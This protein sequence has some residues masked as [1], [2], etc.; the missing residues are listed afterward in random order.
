MHSMA[1]TLRLRGRHKSSTD[2]S[3][4]MLYATVGIAYGAPIE[5]VSIAMKLNCNEWQRNDNI[6]VE[7]MRGT[8]WVGGSCEVLNHC[9]SGVKLTY[10]YLIIRLRSRRFPLNEKWHLFA[11]EKCLSSTEISIRS[12]RSSFYVTVAVSLLVHWNVTWHDKWSI[13]VWVCLRKILALCSKSGQKALPKPIRANDIDVH[14]TCSCSPVQRLTLS[15]MHS[16]CARIHLIIVYLLGKSDCFYYVFP[17]HLK[18]L[19]C[20]LILLW[21]HFTASASIKN[22]NNNS[23]ANGEWLQKPWK[24]SLTL[25]AFRTKQ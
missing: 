10:A 12:R 1:I 20:Q 13:E 7:N 2:K 9:D 25:Y 14:C 18:R 16:Q 24:C 23:N 15:F 19:S 22:N 6:N 8:C 21:E 4:H 3:I 5:L 11:L 17:G